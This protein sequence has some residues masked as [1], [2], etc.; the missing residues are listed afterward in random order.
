[1]EFSLEHL[2]RCLHRSVVLVA[3]ANAPE[4]ARTCRQA[5]GGVMS[6]IRVAGAMGVSSFVSLVPQETGACMVRRL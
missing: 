6:G 4:R 3:G 5:F 2:R 1:M